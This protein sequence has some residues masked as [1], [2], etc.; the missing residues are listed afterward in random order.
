MPS[1]DAAAIFSKAARLRAMAAAS[2]VAGSST[3]RLAEA[4]PAGLWQFRQ[5]A[6]PTLAQTSSAKKRSVTGHSGPAAAPPAI[7]PDVARSGLLAGGEP[8]AGA[9]SGRVGSQTHSPT[10]GN[11]ANMHRIARSRPAIFAASRE[12]CFLNTG[13]TSRVPPGAAG[14]GADSR[15]LSPL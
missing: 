10:A 12:S 9:G 15:T 14:G 5:V 1:A 4:S 2:W 6:S 7:P 11:A 3:N 8:I 13:A